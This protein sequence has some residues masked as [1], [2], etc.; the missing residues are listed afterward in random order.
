VACGR[1]DVALSEVLFGARLASLG[2]VMSFAIWLSLILGLIIMLVGG[3]IL[4]A[5]VGLLAWGI[6]RA[7]GGRS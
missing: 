7:I 2:A 5:I 3:P 6:C 4:G 1:A